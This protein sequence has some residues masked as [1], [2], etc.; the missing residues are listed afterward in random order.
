MHGGGTGGCCIICFVDI[1]FRHVKHINVVLDAQV[2]QEVTFLVCKTLGLIVTIFLGICIAIAISI[3]YVATFFPHLNILL[4][5]QKH[6]VF[7]ASRNK[8]ND[9]PFSKYFK[10]N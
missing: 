1:Q 6:P 4:Y 10:L 7:V 5:T 9:F 8:L 3:F 2:V